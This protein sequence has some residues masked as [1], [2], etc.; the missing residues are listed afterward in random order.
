MNI[1]KKILKFPFYI[2]LILILKGCRWKESKLEKHTWKETHTS[3]HHHMNLWY[4]KN[5]DISTCILSNSEIVSVINT[6]CLL[7]FC[8]PQIHQNLQYLYNNSFRLVWTNYNRIENF[9]SQNLGF[10][11][12]P[13]V[14]SFIFILWL[15]L[16]LHLICFLFVDSWKSFTQSWEIIFGLAQSDYFL[17]LQLWRNLIICH[18][19]Y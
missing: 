11:D 4:E 7:C 9:N 13:A 10:V 16:Y 8:Q 1:L 14:C 17:P 15:W 18:F 19:F 3:G 2:F 5:L 6:I 12:I